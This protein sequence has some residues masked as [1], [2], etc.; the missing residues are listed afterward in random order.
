MSFFGIFDRLSIRYK[1]IVLLCFSSALA[2]VVSLATAFYA[3]YVVET[4]AAQRALRQTADLISENMRAAL[5]FHD[6]ESA[7]NILAALGS[8][9]QIRLALV[10][11]ENGATLGEYH[12]PSSAEEAPL[13]KKAMASELAA[14]AESPSYKRSTTREGF[15]RDYHFLLQPVVFQERPLGR[16][17]IIADNAAIFAKQR[18]FIALQLGATIFIFA[19]IFALSLR[20]QLI[21]TQPINRL[22]RAM[23]EV[24]NSQDYRTHLS[25]QRYQNEFRDLYQ[26]FNSMLA[27]IRRRDE[28]LEAMA[29]TDALTGLANRHMA[30]AAFAEKAGRSARRGEA[31]GVI[32]LDIDRF[33]QINDCYGHAAGDQ[34]LQGI[35]RILQ[36]CARPYDLAARL[37]GEEFLLLC[38]ASGQAATLAI[39]ERIRQRVAGQAFQID[40][41]QLTGRQEIHLT[42]SLGICSA[43][44]DAENFP[45]LLEA[46]DRAL[47]RAKE[48]GRNRCEI[49]EAP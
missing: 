1:L 39:A 14:A 20:L 47:Y 23:R 32:M 37:G 16:L 19:A 3:A 33:K 22:L 6:A 4:A 29:T 26:G 38:D 21:F 10:E 8:S 40:L 13:W 27:E 17:L 11:D 48:G 42:V 30:M 15:S 24:E 36:A 46:A 25:S 12:R 2:L 43:I 28:R 41:P 9:P 35:G 7:K 49:A 45:L 18:Y 44:A 31:L 5:D 34:V